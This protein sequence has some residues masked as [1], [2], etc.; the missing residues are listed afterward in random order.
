[1][2]RR[3]VTLAVLAGSVVWG[4]ARKITLEEAVATAIR[5]HPRIALD[6]LNGL[7]AN[8]LTTEVRSGLFPQ[9]AAN[10]TAAGATTDSRLAAGALN[11]PI[12]FNRYAAGTAISQLITDFGRTSDLVES[13]RLRARSAQ[14]NGLA[15]RAQIT[16][17][18]HRAYFGVLRAAN[19]LKVTEQTI[20]ERE[21]V[22]DQVSALAKSN[23]RSTLDVSFANV[24][25]SEARLAHL[26]A[27][28][29]R[30]VAVADLSAT[31]GYPR[32]RD[33]DPQDLPA[34]MEAPPGAEAL[35]AE[36]MGNRPEVSA[37]RLERESAVRVAAAE[38]K[39]ALPTVSALANMGFSPLHDDRLKNRYAAAGINLSMPLFN[40]Y[41][42]S[43]RR[44]EA[45][46][47]VE[48]VGQRLRDLENEIAREV[49]TAALN[50]ETAFE[51]VGL[52]AQ[53]LKQATLSG[54]L[55]QERYNLGLSSIVELSQAQLNQTAAEIR[56]T[57]AKYEYLLQRSIL[58]Y[59]AGRL[60]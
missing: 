2:T 56:N 31:L 27:Q 47:R 12:I 49:T 50:A 33:F 8:E 58:D 25:A 30:L 19:V 60:R 10:T 7:I 39:L 22:L 13:S 3:F 18:V 32:P 29:E 43:A 15:S 40:G 42:F 57:S 23:L 52:M 37:L 17:A 6:R 34:I 14:E 20:K 45:E 4:Q 9:V 54:E 1:M 5:N 16:L 35:I 26:S 36:A 53:L 41:L 38:R 48:A 44:R 28:N 59:Q 55:A 21:L 46:L 51:R 24:N 11:N